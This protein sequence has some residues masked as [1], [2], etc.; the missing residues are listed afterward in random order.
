MAL[1]TPPQ[2]TRASRQDTKTQE[3]VAAD[4]FGFQGVER[5]EIP[6]WKTF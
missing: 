1:K 5:A 4:E 2:M 6:N 3:N